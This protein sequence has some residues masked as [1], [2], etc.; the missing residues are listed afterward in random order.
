ME[1]LT[2]KGCKKPVDYGSQPEVAMGAIKCPHCSAII[3]QYGNVLKP[4]DIDGG[5]YRLFVDN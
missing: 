5:G 1:P 4:G 3:D 2:C